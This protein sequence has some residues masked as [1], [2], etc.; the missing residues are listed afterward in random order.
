MAVRIQSV[1]PSWELSQLLDIFPL[2]IRQALV[3]LNNLEDIIEVVLDLGARRKLDSSTIRLTNR[4]AGFARR[5][6]ARLLAALAVR[7]R[8]PRRHRADAASHQRD[9]QSHRED[10]RSH[11][12]RRPRRLRH[13]RHHARRDAQRQIDLF[14]GASGRRKDDDAARVRARAKRR[15]QTCRD[16]RH[17]E[18][19]RRR[20]RHPASRHR[21]RP[22]H[23]GCRSRS[24]S[25]T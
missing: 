3:R 10:R 7:R 8:Q 5:H 15:S 19:N 23:A 20:Q 9:S 18:R 24:C 13:D 21:A 6:R 2:A 25:T 22:A 14:A 4:D 17:V 16:R 12:P 1:S 11:V